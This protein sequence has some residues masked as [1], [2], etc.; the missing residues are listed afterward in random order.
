MTTKQGP[1]ALVLLDS[2]H[3]VG[4]R[5]F[6]VSSEKEFKHRGD[7]SWNGFIE[8]KQSKSILS[9]RGERVRSRTRGYPEGPKT[10]SFH[11]DL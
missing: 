11:S 10:T 7:L 9:M 6:L 5:K 3:L 8:V 2:G 4:D 1:W